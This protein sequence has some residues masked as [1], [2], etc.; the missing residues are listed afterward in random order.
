[1]KDHLSTQI[2]EIGLLIRN[3]DWSQS[4][5]GAIDSWSV[6]LKTAVEILATELERAKMSVSQ[7]STAVAMT[8]QISRIESKYDL[9][10]RALF[11]SINQGFSVCEL[12][13]DD[14]GQEAIDYRFIEVNDAFEA[15]AGLESVEGKLA[16]EMLPN[17]EKFWFETY[18]K[19]VLTRESVRVEHQVSGLDRWFEVNAFPIESPQKH[20]FG[21]LFTDISDR[22]RQELNV[23]FLA[24][25]QK[26][27][28]ILSDTDQIMSV[29]G[30][31][32]RSFFD[33]S[34]LVFADV[35]VEADRAITVFNVCD[36]DIRDAVSSHRLSDYWSP[37]HLDKIKA[38]QAIAISDVTTDR[39]IKDGG[40]AY[41]TYQVRSVICASYL[42]AG[43]CKFLIGGNRRQPSTWRADELELMDEL[44]TR[45]YLCIERAR[46]EE[47]LQKVN[48][49]F[50]TAMQSIDGIVFECSP[51]GENIYRSEGLFKLIGV[52]AED[53]LPTREWWQERIHPDDLT[54]SSSITMAQSDGDRYQQEYRIL[55]TDG[56]W[57]DVW[58]QGYLQRNV[59]GEITGVVGFI[60][61]ISDRKYAERRLR[62]SQR[63]YR[64]IGETIDYGI[65]VNDAQGQNV[66]T[67]ASFL[68]MLGITQEQ[69]SGL[70]WSQYLHPQERDRTV[71]AWL[72]CVKTEGNWDIQHRYRGLDGNYHHV[73]ARGVPVRNNLGKI[74]CWAGINLDISRF[75]QSEERLRQ[76]EERLRLTIEGTSAGTWD[77][78]LISGKLLWSEQNFRLFG[79]EPNPTGAATNEM[80]NDRLHPED[81]ERVNQLWQESLDQGTQFNSEHRIVRFDNQQT[82]WIEVLGSFVYDDNDRAIRS[83]G[84]IFDI[85]DRKYLEE[86][87]YYSR[88]R[89]NLVIDSADLGLW[90]CDLPFNQ[91]EL[92]DTCKAHL[93]LPLDIPITID[94][95]YEHVHF[96]DR[97]RVK[98]QINASIE[99][100]QR[101]DVDYRTVASNGKVC[102]IRAMG[103]VFYDSVG[104]PLRFDSV[105]M[106]MTKQKEIEQDLYHSE[107]RYRHLAESIPQLVWI[108]NLQ[109]GN[110]YVNQQ[111]C[112]YTGLDFNQLMGLDWEIIIHPDD[113][114]ETIQRWKSS[115]QLDTLYEIEYRLRAADG[116][117]RWHLGRAIPVKDEEGNTVRLFG[118]ATDIEE[119]KK[120]EQKLAL[121]IEQVQERNQELDQF[122]HIVSHDLKA[123]LRAIANLAEWIEDD[124]AD[125]VP[126]ESKAQMQ[127]LRNRVYRMNALL[128][129]ILEFAKIGRTEVKVETV[130]VPSLVAEIVDSLLLPP[131]FT[132]EVDPNLPIL[133]TQAILLRQ[134]FTNLLDNAIKHHP[135]SGGW[136]KVTSQDLGDYYEFAIADNGKGIEPESQEKIF[137]IF[138]TLENNNPDSTGV[139]LAIVKKIVTSE[140]GKIYL[141]S[142][143][144]KGSTFYFTWLKSLP[145]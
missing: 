23:N 16:S 126:E 79:Y 141:K 65:W 38:G 12:Y 125:I 17:L 89:L 128:D 60:A 25:I 62:E 102:W 5:L 111:M 13:F 32:I 40:A 66:Y 98:A 72:E 73:L 33:F 108:S 91:L 83:T 121:T 6:E 2:G 45:I 136:V 106:D 104:K 103:Q 132:V 64:A 8:P 20:R 70:D 75:K 144:D 49:H 85:S 28:V 18:A 22:Q 131:D 129:G 133:S 140:G 118:T 68:E 127:L 46:A 112:A 63:I 110:E 82:L 67:S 81:R 109:G 86:A 42:R 78:D 47:A 80:W 54:M 39:N 69:C 52:R 74:I 99:N 4:P 101:Y 134:V 124:I 36:P 119:Q 71:Q 135:D 97:D 48:H 37:E 113:W 26:D 107:A 34:I 51:P 58:E 41:A 143:V 50:E 29:V 115:V 122:A 11:N 56:R 14:R 88:E 24:E 76:S 44:T 15:I 138:Q 31:K 92:N 116:S 3:Y 35:D 94:L 10:Y 117:Y 96:C 95:F 1:M 30:E 93:G 137:L 7:A 142:E 43:D 130:S 145:A 90:Y 55:H 139:G 105:T 61:D 9:R 59:Q 27:L 19:V 57:I 84:V 114:A 123:P 77:L 120:L 100:R 87:L 21:I 53:A